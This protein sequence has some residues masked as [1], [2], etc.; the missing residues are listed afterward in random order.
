MKAELFERYVHQ[1]GR[2]LPRKQRADVE[3]ELY[4]LLMD[5]LMDRTEGREL[6]SRELKELQSAVLLEMGPPEQVADKYR[7]RQRYVIGP[8]LFDLYVIVVAAVSG[9]LAL[10]FFIMMILSL[11]GGPLSGEALLSS[12]GS[13]LLN[14]VQAILPVIGTMTIVFAI[15]ERVLPDSAEDEGEWDPRSLPEIENRTE[16]GRA[17]LVFEIG[18]IIAALLLFNVFADWAGI[19]FFGSTADSAQDWRMLPVLSPAFFS[20][21]LPLL[22]VAWLLH[23]GLN[24][25]LLWQGRWQRV[26]R[27]AQFLL[28]LFDVYILYR[29]VTGPS[30]VTFLSNLFQIGF[31]IALVVT[32]I[33]AVHKLY[34]VIRGEKTVA[35]DPIGQAV[36]G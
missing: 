24:I 36:E 9:A 2:R 23:I 14:C 25:V 7:P 33:S 20:V 32:A 19:Y 27:F 3:A 1:V 29:L 28:A 6:D 8:R 21:Y 35:P 22:N 13:F 5:S 18:L 10:A 34:L 15:L 30:P 31:A 16:I 12:I 17:S 11:L 4:S 26:T